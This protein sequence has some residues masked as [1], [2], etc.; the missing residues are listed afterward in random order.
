ML[1][2]NKFGTMD[3]IIHFISYSYRIQ[4]IMVIKTIDSVYLE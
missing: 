4:N 2:F 3:F 1:V